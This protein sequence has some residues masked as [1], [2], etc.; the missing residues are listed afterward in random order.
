MK[1][2]QKR[3]LLKTNAV[4]C[5]LNKSGNRFIS[6][7]LKKYKQTTTKGTEHR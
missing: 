3:Y 7:F 6:D 5:N 1:Q 2:M 4:D